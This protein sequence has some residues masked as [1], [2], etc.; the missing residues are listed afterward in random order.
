MWEENRK[1]GNPSQSKNISAY[2]LLLLLQFFGSFSSQVMTWQILLFI[3]PLKNLKVLSRSGKA[4]EPNLTYNILCVSELIGSRCK[5][6]FP[7]NC[8][9]KLFRVARGK[10]LKFHQQFHQQ[11][12]SIAEFPY[13]DLFIIFSL[14]NADNSLVYNGVRIFQ[15][16][17]SKV[18]DKRINI[19]TRSVGGR[20]MKQFVARL[21]QIHK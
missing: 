11:F 19:S 4:T 16:R 10:R 7:L 2:A 8:N 13:L 9:I 12:Q 21:P 17:T 15:Y 5:S 1:P 20:D 3:Y 18:L 14:N 6:S